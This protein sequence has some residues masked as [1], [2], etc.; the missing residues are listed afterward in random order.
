V[1]EQHKPGGPAIER[2]FTLELRDACFCV[3]QRD[4]EALAETPRQAGL[5]SEKPASCQ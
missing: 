3:P 2:S 5:A 1:R 4:W